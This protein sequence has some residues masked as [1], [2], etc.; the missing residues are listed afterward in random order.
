MPSLAAWATSSAAIA[1]GVAVLRSAAAATRMRSSW[2]RALVQTSRTSGSDVSP[3]ASSTAGMSWGRNGA[4]SLGWSTS[5]DMLLAILA[6][7]RR[8][9]V[10]S[11]KPRRSSGAT[12][13][14]AAPET[15]WT[16]VVEAS[17]WMHSP[18]S[19]G[20]LSALIRAGMNGVRSLFW[21]I[22]Q[23]A[24]RHSSAASAT[25]CLV[26]H[27][28][29]VSTG[30]MSGMAWAICTGALDTR[31]I[32]SCRLVCF[33]CHLIIFR[34]SKM[35][36][37][38]GTAVLGR[39]AM[40]SRSGAMQASAAVRAA[41]SFS[42]TI[43]S[44]DGSICSRYGS[45]GW[46]TCSTMARKNSIRPTRAAAAFFL[47]VVASVSVVMILRACSERRPAVSLM[48]SANSLAAVLCDSP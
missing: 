48:N 44:T 6:A 10:D 5:L 33:D 45:A 8:T 24:V 15:V 20:S 38:S 28:M 22:S 43:S 26:S 29:S 30:T 37:S 42:P 40:S 1:A 34:P 19:F 25:D 46:P 36:L 3:E 4:A 9:A 41:A 21:T 14:R 7:W 13:A 47:S 16:N 31:L 35:T 39:G 23:H 11:R 32:I 2:A 27:I 17:W 18:T 12:R